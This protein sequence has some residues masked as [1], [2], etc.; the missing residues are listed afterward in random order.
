MCIPWKPALRMPLSTVSTVILAKPFAKS[1][2]ALATGVPSAVLSCVVN[3]SVPAG[4]GSVAFS[5]V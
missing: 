2:V 1:R 3:L 4:A 5:S